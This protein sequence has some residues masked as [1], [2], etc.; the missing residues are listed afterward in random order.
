MTAVCGGDI[1]DDGGADITARGV[2]WS[3]SQNPTISD[4]LTTDG[5][6]TGSF[7]SDIAGLT[8]VL[9]VILRD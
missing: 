9:R 3:M 6:G 7:T 8:E 4:S 5:S 1:A 2:C